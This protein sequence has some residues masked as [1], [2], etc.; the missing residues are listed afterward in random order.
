[1]IDEAIPFLLFGF[2]T[3]AAFWAIGAKFDAFAKALGFVSMD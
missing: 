1:M 3:G 2:L